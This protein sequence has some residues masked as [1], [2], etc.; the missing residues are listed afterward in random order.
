MSFII[1]RGEKVAVIGPNG[2]GK[3]TLLKILTGNVAADGGTV[4]LG[5]EVRIGYFAQDHHEV[6]KGAQQTP[7]DYVWDICPAEGTAYVRGQLGRVPLFGV[8]TPAP[9][10]STRARLPAT[11]PLPS[12]RQTARPSSTALSSA[13][14]RSSGRS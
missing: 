3:S 1:R 12:A 2:L 6:L 10:E 14:L 11:R 7:L 5:H 13:A 4:K 9:G 8:C